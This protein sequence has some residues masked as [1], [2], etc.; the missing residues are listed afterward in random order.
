[1]L[2][3]I[4]DCTATL[5]CLQAGDEDRSPSRSACFW[6]DDPSSQYR[7]TGAEGGFTFEE[8]R[9][10]VGQSSGVRGLRRRWT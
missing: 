7:C 6:T 1:M 10:Q 4:S 3:T 9:R 8:Q 5:L 2:S